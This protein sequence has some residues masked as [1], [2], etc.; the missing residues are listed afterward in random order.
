VGKKTGSILHNAVR[1][2]V[3]GGETRNPLTK[4][5][6]SP[7]I[8]GDPGKKKRGKLLNFFK[9]EKTREILASPDTEEK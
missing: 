7:N 1:V 3:K 4:N 9:Q 5:T 2:V 8:K 6:P